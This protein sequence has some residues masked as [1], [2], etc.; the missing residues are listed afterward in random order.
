MKL[1]RYLVPAL[2]LLVAQTSYATLIYQQNFESLTA[3]A[4]NNAASA[5]D[6]Q[7]QGGFTAPVT[8]DVI[9]TGLSYNSGGVSVSGGSKGGY[10][11]QNGASAYMFSNT[12]TAQ[13]G[14][15]YFS[16]VWSWTGSDAPT[17]TF[18]FLISGQTTLPG[19]P[20]LQSAAGVRINNNGGA[21]GSSPNNVNIHARNFDSSATALTTTGPTANTQGTANFLVGKLSKSG[22]NGGAYDQISIWVNPTSATEGAATLTAS[23]SITA[24]SVDKF[25]IWSAAN[26][27]AAQV[28]NFDNILIGTTYADVVTA[29][30]PEPS[31]YAAFAGVGVLGLAALRRRRN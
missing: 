16:L 18:A 26:S 13:T 4:I 5:N 24:T 25:Y 23:Q 28:F 29:A 14:D 17:E 19:T 12:M 2:S 8:T 27:S 11:T 9:N 10:A 7:G 6:L 15:V 21:G 30:V 3:G 20:T 22:G 31:T 1:H